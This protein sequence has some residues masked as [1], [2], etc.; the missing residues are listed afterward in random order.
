MD[1]ARHHERRF[2][3]RAWGWSDGGHDVM[4]AG[5]VL[6]TCVGMVRWSGR[7]VA[8]D[9][10]SPHVRGDGPC[11]AGCFP[12]STAF[13]PRAWGWSVGPSPHPSPSAV[14]PTCVGMVRP[15][16]SSP[17]PAS[18]SPHVRGDG[19]QVLPQELT[20]PAFSPRAWGWS[21]VC[22]AMAPKKEVL[23][24]CVGMVRNES[25]PRSNASCSPHVRGD[26]PFWETI[27]SVLAGFSPRAWGWSG[28]AQSARLLW[29]VLPTC[30]GMVR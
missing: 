22:H 6:P 27:Q 15:R 13:S 24:T 12:S 28:H 11:N 30:M 25:A 19:P 16:P 7:I 20:P 8:G 17:G 18:G 21:V 4:P 3:P 14:L 26:G 1:Q 9:G 2:S 5:E 10:C 29:A 23:P